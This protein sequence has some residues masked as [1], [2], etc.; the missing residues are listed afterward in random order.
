M[1]HGTIGYEDLP[2]VRLEAV[3]RRAGATALLLVAAGAVAL[4]L[5]L[6]TD[7]TRAWR[8]YLFNWLFWTSI[9]QGAVLLG[10][11]VVMTRGVWSRSLRR[12]ALSFVAFLPLAFL[13]LIPLF[14]VGERIFP[15]TDMEL[16]AGK[17]AWL[18]VPFVAARNIFLFG[19]LVLVSLA[20]A[21]W[22]LRPDV[23][24]LRDSAPLRLRGWY[25]RLSRGW[26][27]Q[28]AEETQAHH[29][30]A[31]LA[32]VFTLVYALAFSFLA[33]DLVMSL[34]PNWWSTLLGPYF[35]MAAFLGGIAATAVVSVVYRQSLGLAE[36][37]EPTQL[38]DI[39]KLTFAF[40]I[41]WAY[42]FWAQF[43][44]I[45]YGLL[46]HEQSF[47]VR[48]FSDPFGGVAIFVL[49]AMFVVP[50]FGLLGVK[51]KKTPAL[52]ATFSVIVL[53]GLWV[54]RYL[55][56]YPSYYFAADELVFGWQE[57]G[58]GL[59]FAGLMLGSLLFFATRF[60][61]FQLWQPLSELELLGDTGEPPI[62]RV[63]A[64]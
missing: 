15:W 38:H 60:P 53:I 22:A 5:A 61:L 57:I 46:P 2:V 43:I 54:E 6:L 32:P 20:F 1:A 37:I 45:W 24:L 23:G 40:V 48:R 41:F 50:F 12:I 9:A 21:Y 55:L 7:A 39:G 8:A 58:I 44:V 47:V 16:P 28:E 42:L 36:A 3:P 62:D 10:A 25:E 14:F 18:N 17:E 51:P 33:F 56:I 34:E 26:R 13:L 4:V 27:G 30:L 64:E 63:T 29:K 59:G 52:L 11:T 31:R 49:C 35:F 19:A